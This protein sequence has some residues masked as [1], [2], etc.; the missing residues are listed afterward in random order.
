MQ[1]MET[2]SS[3]VYNLTGIELIVCFQ[4]RLWKKRFRSNVFFTPIYQL[5]SEDE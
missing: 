1:M 4:T 3:Y 2:L 5:S